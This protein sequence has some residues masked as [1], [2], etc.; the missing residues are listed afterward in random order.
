[1]EAQTGKS[2]N[3]IPAGAGS[4]QVVLGDHQTVKLTG[5]E[6]GGAFAIIEQNNFPGVMVPLHYHTR[7][8]EIFYIVEGELEFTIE[9]KVILAKGGTTVHVP[10]EVEHAFKVIGSKPNKTIITLV[11]AGAEEMFRKLSLLPPGPPDFEKVKAI[12]QEYGIYF[13]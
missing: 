2:G 3:V 9:G 7:E 6:T 11:P 10:R 1:M 4:R 5:R 8:D 12:C 13:A